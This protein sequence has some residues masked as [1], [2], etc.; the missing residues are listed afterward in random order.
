[1]QAGLCAAAADPAS[2]AAM[3]TEMRPAGELI[4]AQARGGRR[5]EPV[6]V[7]RVPRVQ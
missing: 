4:G 7:S 3:R 6:G 5:E 2:E 1:L